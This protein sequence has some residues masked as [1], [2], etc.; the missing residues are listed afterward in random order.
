MKTGWKIFLIILVILI[1]LIIAFAIFTY[2][3]I[4]EVYGFANN[5]ELKQDIADLTEGNCSKLQ[6]LEPKINQIQTSI[7]T[8]CINPVIRILSQKIKVYNTDICVE[9]KNPENQIQQIINQAKT[10]CK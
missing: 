4:K 2:Y 5:P 3:Q 9:I 7:K 1:L 8:A 6:I 10:M